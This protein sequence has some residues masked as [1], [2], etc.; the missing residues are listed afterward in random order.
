MRGH[1]AGA[2]AAGACLAAS[3]AA[4]SSQVDAWAAMLPSSRAT[5]MVRLASGECVVTSRHGQTMCPSI[6]TFKVGCDIQNCFD[7]ASEV[8]NPY[9]NG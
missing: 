3:S 9:A 2:A 8:I 5:S 1:S 4:I 6:L 7:R